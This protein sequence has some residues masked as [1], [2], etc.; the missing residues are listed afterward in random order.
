MRGLELTIK[1]EAKEIAALVLE[2]Q[3]RPSEDFPNYIPAD[4]SMDLTARKQ[5]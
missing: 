4:S 1:G 2:L 3:G 5:S